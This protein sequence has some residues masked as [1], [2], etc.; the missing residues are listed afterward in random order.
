MLVVTSPVK[1]SAGS[2]F[3]CHTPSRIEVHGQ[4][5]YMAT[6]TLTSDNRI[7]ERHSL[8]IGCRK[9]N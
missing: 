2:F 4:S 8:V 9:E 5:K 7:W 1:D 3:Y 6:F